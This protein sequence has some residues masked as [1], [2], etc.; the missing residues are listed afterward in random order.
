M[1]SPIFH[2]STDTGAA[3]KILRVDPRKDGLV[4]LTLSCRPGGRL[5]MVFSPGELRSV[6]LQLLRAIPSAKTGT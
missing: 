4:E 3:I 2:Y 5:S 6:A 1:P